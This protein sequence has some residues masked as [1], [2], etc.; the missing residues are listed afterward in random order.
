VPDHLFKDYSEL[1]PEEVQTARSTVASTG[2]GKYTAPSDTQQDLF[3]ALVAEAKPVIT[4]LVSTSSDFSAFLADKDTQAFIS[5]VTSTPDEL[6]DHHLTGL[7]GPSRKSQVSAIAWQ[8]FWDSNAVAG[9]VRKFRCAQELAQILM[10]TDV[11]IPADEL[12]LPFRFMAVKLPSGMF[13]LDE[14]VLGGA[15]KSCEY[16]CITKQ[17]LVA[18]ISPSLSSLPTADLDAQGAV[19]TLNVMVISNVD[20]SDLK[21]GVVL[22]DSMPLRSGKTVADELDTYAEIKEGRPSGWSNHV[23]LRLE[24][25]PGTRRDPMLVL[26]NLAAN[27]ALYCTNRS[28]DVVP[29]NGA[30]LDRLT[31]RVKRLPAGKKRQRAQEALNEARRR[32]VLVIGG[33]FRARDQ[34]VLLCSKLPHSISV[35]HMV[36]GHWKQQV[37][38]QGRQDRKHIFV[39]PYWRGP[40]LAEVLN[41][42]YKLVAPTQR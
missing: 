25:A 37:C 3:D 9:R 4:R 40:E 1:S 30:T 39:E 14:A 42:D 29:S 31:T 10:Y 21:H 41:R 36:R 27:L 38:G 34:Q 8:A 26:F 17:K 28:A 35:R 5:F 13:L 20:P 2:R 6:G 33:G 15:P 32:T 19:D 12:Q 11:K 24:N 18:A 23:S 16:L 22:V 7:T